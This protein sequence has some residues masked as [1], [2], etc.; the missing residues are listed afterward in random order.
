MVKERIYSPFAAL[1]AIA[2][3]TSARKSRFLTPTFF[4]FY[5]V[6]FGDMVDV[7][8]GQP[9]FLRYRFNGAIPFICHHVHLSQLCKVCL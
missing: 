9:V 3:S 7:C 6:N 4:L 8:F 5:A 1:S 2:R